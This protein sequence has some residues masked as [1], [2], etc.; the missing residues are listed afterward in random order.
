VRGEGVPFRTALRIV[1]EVVVEALQ[2]GKSAG[3]IDAEAVRR[4]AE[5]A[6]GRRLALEDSTVRRAL[7]AWANVCG[8]QTLGSPTPDETRRMVAR[9]R[10]TLLGESAW[11]AEKHQRLAAAS[12]ALEEAI[13]RILAS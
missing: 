12:A 6:L 4:A 7:D 9:A 2:A 3:A 1:A 11:L 10:A 5:R 8:R 13:D